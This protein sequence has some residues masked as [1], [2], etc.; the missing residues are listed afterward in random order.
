MGVHT[1]ITGLNGAG[2][3]LYAVS[4]KL[5]P[6]RDATIEYRGE[7]IPRRIVQGGI[8]GLLI[9]HELM[10][11]PE[12]NPE[13]FLDEWATHTREPGTPPVDGVLCSILNW[14]L[15]CKPGDFIVVDEC[16]RVFR[17]MASG[18]R[19][20]MFISK[21]E[22]ARHYG[23]EFLYLTQ[24]P[25]LVH[26]NVRR[27]IGPHENVRRIFGGSRT[28]I[29]QW[30]TASDPD[31]IAKATARYWK[32]DPSAFALYKSSELHHKFGQRLP[33]AVWGVVVGLVA[34]VGMGYYLA[35][36]MHHRF[37]DDTSKSTG[38]PAS[39][40]GAVPGAVPSTAPG[41]SPGGAAS[42]ELTVQDAVGG[43]TERAWPVYRAEPYRVGREPL[44][45]RA[46]QYEGGYVTGSTTVAYFGLLIDGQRVSTVTLAQLVSMGYA[47]TTLG[48][49]V[50]S[51]RFGRLERLVTCPK[52]DKVAVPDSHSVVPAAA[53]STPA[54]G[55]LA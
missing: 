33:L 25:Q 54:G 48:P 13:T 37:G 12:I 11:V 52:R 39:L 29:Y 22:T 50:G 51:L 23:V 16:Q 46:V 28:M 21:L 53:A 34:L 4:E 15:W 5:R 8:N 27:L 26:Q 6:L 35:T 17:P 36:R 44:D 20:P 31:R 45:G 24:H 7:L 30:D 2:K 43:K 1:L 9:E 40:P 3:T 14:W 38:A 41:A 10:E 42:H 19:V 49:C 55:P 32:H 18:K 47:W